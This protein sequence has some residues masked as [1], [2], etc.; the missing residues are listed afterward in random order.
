[1]ANIVTSAG[2]S[3]DTKPTYLILVNRRQG[4][5]KTTFFRGGSRGPYYIYMLISSLHLCL[6]GHW[7]CGTTERAG[8][9]GT[10]GIGRPFVVSCKAFGT[11]VELYEPLSFPGCL[12]PYYLMHSL[13]THLVDGRGAT[14]CNMNEWVSKLIWWLQA[15]L[16]V[17]LLLPLALLEP[18][19]SPHKQC[20]I[21]R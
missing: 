13:P 9:W 1:M 19:I 17:L 2:S 18:S 21:Q 12:P 16:V 4:A 6:L 14:P 5:I 8:N 7:R 20:Q 15:P 3:H 11:V 10:C